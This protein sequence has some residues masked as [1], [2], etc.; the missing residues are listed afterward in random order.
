MAEEAFYLF[1]SI[2]LFSNTH[3][4]V[5]KACF[6]PECSWIHRLHSLSLSVLEYKRF[7]FIKLMTQHARPAQQSQRDFS[8]SPSLFSPVIS[9][10][11]Y[12][13]YM[14]RYSCLYSEHFVAAFTLWP[15]IR[16]DPSE[17]V[18]RRNKP[19]ANPIFLYVHNENIIQNGK[20]RISR[21]CY[22]ISWRNR[23]GTGAF[24]EILAALASKVQ[25]AVDSIHKHIF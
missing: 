22:H 19:T 23:K 8:L 25:V 3:I 6:H 11:Q 9:L 4:L 14:W 21:S 15:H 2:T 17:A 13:I 12:L 20:N 16:R 24:R 18:I 5:F 1:S 7:L 10:F